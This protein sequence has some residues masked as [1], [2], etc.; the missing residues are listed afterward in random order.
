[1]RDALAPYLGQRITVSAPVKRFGTRPGWNGSKL[2]TLLVGPVLAADGS[3]ITDHLWLHVGQRIALADPQLGDTLILTGRV[4]PYTRRRKPIGPGPAVALTDLGL[5]YPTKCAVV[6]KAEVADVK[7]ETV[8]PFTP[9]PTPPTESVDRSNRITPP[10]NEIPAR[11]KVLFALALLSLEKTD[12]VS[13]TE[14]SAR[15]S[16][17]PVAFLSQLKK[18]GNAGIVQFTPTGRVLLTNMP[19]ATVIGVAQ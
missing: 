8:S 10:S 7:G 15:A 2:P 1:M 18:M 5:C 16:V 9:E 14:L 17:P 19:T 12:G 13:L 6:A 4:R 3:E 11:A